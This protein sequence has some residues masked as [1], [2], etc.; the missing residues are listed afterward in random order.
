M[1]LS[2]AFGAYPF[3]IPFY[4]MI[5]P[6]HE[7]HRVVVVSSVSYDLFLFDYPE[8]RARMQFII[9]V[10]HNVIHQ[11]WFYSRCVNDEV[12]PVT[13]DERLSD[14][15]VFDEFA[16]RTGAAGEARAEARRGRKRFGELLKGF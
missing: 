6:K 5:V 11:L 13:I 3:T 9:G 14:L 1:A 2:R 15:P 7:E 10:P 8:R 4:R 16:P 12:V